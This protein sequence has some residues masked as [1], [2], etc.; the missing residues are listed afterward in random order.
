MP[1]FPEFTKGQYGKLTAEVV[2][3]LVSQVSKNTEFITNFGFGTTTQPRGGAGNFPIIAQLGA[4]ILPEVDEG[5]G[6]EPPEGS[7]SRYRERRGDDGEEGEGGE[8]G[9]GGKEDPVRIGY[10]WTEVYLD[11]TS[12]EGSPWVSASRRGYSVARNNPAF[13][14]NG[15]SFE[16]VQDESGGET[17]ETTDA[18]NFEGMVVLL[19]P[20]AN[21]QGKSI[22]VF[23]SPK[24]P[25]T[26]LA[27]IQGDQN[28]PPCRVADGAPY[29]VKRFVD[30]EE[31]GEPF[32]ALNGCEP[33]GMGGQINGTDCTIEMPLT[34]VPAG[35][36]VVC[37]KVNGSHYFNATNERCVTCCEEEEPLT[38]KE[39]TL[40]NSS[41]TEMAVRERD[42]GYMSIFAEMMR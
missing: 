1:E 3:D 19:Y 18:N 42:P 23:Q 12:T 34:R 8:G 26:F 32:D 16:R 35:T 21:N 9:E 30:N 25:S 41:T 24:N 38:I 10:K 6:G 37:V 28:D 11:E 39:T 20:F 36:K 14:T 15:F 4:R 22:L 7:Q 31:V 33:R 29:L 13:P 40:L 5:E 27:V 17:E 2:N